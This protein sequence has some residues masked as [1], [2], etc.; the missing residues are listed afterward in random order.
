MKRLQNGKPADHIV[1][2]RLLGIV[3]PLGRHFP[4]VGSKMGAFFLEKKMMKEWPEID[5]SWKLLP[6]PPILNS[7]PVLN[8][9]VIPLMASGSLTSVTGIKSFI[10]THDVE[11][12]DGTILESIDAVIFCTGYYFDYSI[13][14]P[15]ANPT[16]DTN[17]EWNK[18]PHF[19]GLAY[20]RI[21]KTLLSP[22]HP[23]TLAF[24][25]P[26]RGHSFAA[27][28]NADLSSQALSQ[29]W[30]GNH[31]LP[32]QKE[33]ETWCDKNYAENLAL[34]T[35][36]HIHKVGMDPREL[37]KW[38]NEVTANGM[39]EM[40]GWTSWEAWK[41]WWN[42]RELYKLIMDGVDTPFV[43]KLFDSPRGEMGRKSW[44]GAREAIYKTNGRTYKRKVE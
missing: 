28:S 6:A 7:A 9:D 2:R 26:F 40:F 34:M 14:S 16:T 22:K 36:W 29:L 5:P 25:G 15:E 17:E 33:M 38:L 23:S 35:D 41:F 30:L 44:E 18:S 27:F 13:L 19:N 10:N 21:Y 4:K 31:A 39:N 20:P 24:I 32:S 1:S 3:Q 43:Y 11:L 12:T 37:E 8:D 42:E